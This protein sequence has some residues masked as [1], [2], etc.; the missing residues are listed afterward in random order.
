MDWD[1]LR[2]WV[3]FAGLSFW[4]R[5]FEAVK[6]IDADRYDGSMGFCDLDLGLMMHN[7]GCQVCLVDGVT[8]F[9]DDSETGSHRHGILQRQHQTDPHRNARLFVE[10]W[11][12]EEAAKYGITW[13]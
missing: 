1:K 6:G 13:P 4:R 9:I 11:G 7:D 12:A 3:S 8:C 10:K 5:D 2:T